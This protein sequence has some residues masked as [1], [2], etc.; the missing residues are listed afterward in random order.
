[1][2]PDNLVNQVVGFVY[3][4]GNTVAIDIE[5]CII[6]PVITMTIFGPLD[7]TRAHVFYLAA[8]INKRVRIYFVF[9]RASG[10]MD[11]DLAAL[12]RV[13]VN[14]VMIGVINENTFLGTDYPVTRYSRIVR[15][16][17]KQAAFNVSR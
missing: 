3:L 15:G 13:V 12:K 16:I 14:L 5:S 11:T 7:V 9:F 4:V 6:A 8:I 1:M 17:E 2:P 10:E